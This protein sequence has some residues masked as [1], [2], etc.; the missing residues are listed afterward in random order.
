[1][2]NFSMGKGVYILDMFNNIQMPLK[3][4]L[5]FGIWMNCGLIGLYSQ[6]SLDA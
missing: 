4:Y 3:H 5:K 2:C 1:M 6:K